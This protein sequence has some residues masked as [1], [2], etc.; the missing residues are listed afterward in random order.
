MKDISDGGPLLAGTSWFVSNVA[1][2]MLI[3][4]CI[5]QLIGITTCST[6]GS[7]NE[8]IASGLPSSLKAPSE[9]FGMYGVVR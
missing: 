6:I 5:D 4:G 3:P 9:S 1:A 2:T 8:D 7:T